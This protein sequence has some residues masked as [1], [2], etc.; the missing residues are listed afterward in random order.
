[1]R[2]AGIGLLALVTLTGCG[3]IVCCDEGDGPIVEP[4]KKYFV[5]NADQLDSKQSYYKKEYNRLWNVMTR[6]FFSERMDVAPAKA[7]ETRSLERTMRGL[8][9]SI[10]SKYRRVLN[11]CKSVQDC[12][13]VN[14][15]DSGKCYSVTQELEQAKTSFYSVEQTLESLAMRLNNLRYETKPPVISQPTA[16]KPAPEKPESPKTDSSKVNR[17]K[18]CSTVGTV[19]T[20][21]K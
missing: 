2:T 18:D 8:E 20:E 19:F 3:H 1:M 7:S 9:Y 5:C 13:E 11:N 12:Y 15:Y 10:D 14:D 4:P 17:G 6:E 21:C 16:P